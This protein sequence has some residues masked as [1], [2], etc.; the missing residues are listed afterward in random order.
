MAETFFFSKVFAT[1][2]F[3]KILLFYFPCILVCILT[4]CEI[5]HFYIFRYDISIYTESESESE[6]VMTGSELKCGQ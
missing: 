3:M 1:T 4:W 5:S 2:P 6:I